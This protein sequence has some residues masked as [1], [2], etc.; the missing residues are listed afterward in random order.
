[1]LDRDPAAAAQD[2]SRPDASPQPTAVVMDRQGVR[3]LGRKA[4][5]TRLRVLQAAEAV[6]GDFGYHGAAITEITR[7]ARVSQGTFYLYFESK[8]EIFRAL[9]RQISA[10][11]RHATSVAAAGGRDRLEAERLGFAA[12]FR[13]LDHHP[14]LY[15]IVRESEFVDKDLFVWYYR[16]L[17]ENYTR[18]LRAAMERGEVRPTDP[19]ALAWS[20]MGVAETVGMRYMV[21]DDAS[22]IAPVFE[23]IMEFVIGG[24]RPDPAGSDANPQGGEAGSRRGPSR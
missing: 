3:P 15:R 7:R 21:W 17:G 14:R 4:Q 2:P 22:G 5:E 9:V 20:L 18:R 19:E 24:L 8:L 13:Y 10:E 11:V 6:F 12:F 16:T 23:T 1:M